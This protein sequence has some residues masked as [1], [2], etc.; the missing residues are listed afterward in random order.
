MGAALAALGVLR[1]SE[2]ARQ[3]LLASAAKLRAALGSAGFDVLDGTHP[4]VT[5][6]SGNAV[7]AQRMTDMLYDRGLYVMGFCHP[8]VPEGAARVRAQLTAG[9]TTEM[10]DAVVAAY[11]GAGRELGLV[12]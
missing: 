5:I 7:A 1:E 11:V 9:H 12:A 2:S 10:V 3:A 4:I 8:V 6:V